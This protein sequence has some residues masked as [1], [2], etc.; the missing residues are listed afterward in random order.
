M[1]KRK[2]KK[3]PEFN[4]T[5]LPDIIF[6]L[7]FF[8]MVATVLRQVDNDLNLVLPKTTYGEKLNNEKQYLEIKILSDENEYRYSLN[9]KSCKYID[10][11]EKELIQLLSVKDG[12]RGIE[13]KLLID[14]KTKMEEVNLLKSILQSQQLFTVKYIIQRIS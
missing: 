13:V 3:V 12:N 7:L 14:G 11:L 2:E 4:T 10:E 5:A 9:N 8:F 1:I 6:M